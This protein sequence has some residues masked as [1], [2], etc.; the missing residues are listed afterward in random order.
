MSD[1]PQR[2]TVLVVDDTETNIDIMLDALNDEYDVSVALDGLTALENCAHSLP[3]IILLDIMMPDIDGYEVCRR[4]KSDANTRDVPIIFI[5]AMSDPS[6]EVVGLTLGAVDYI[7]KP[8]SIP[9]VQARVKAHLA[10]RQAQLALANQNAI[11]EQK[12]RQRTA[13][14]RQSRLTTITCLGRAAEHRDP[15]TGSHIQRMSNYS[16]ALALACGLSEDEAE[17][18]L[19]AAP[20]HDIGKVGVPDR[21]L[22]KPGPL[23]YDEREIMKTH[24]LIG[25]EILGHEPSKLLQL[26]CQ[27]A[28]THHEKWDGS[29]YPLGLHR[30][31]IPLH[32]RIVA[33]ADVFDAL[34]SERPYKPAWG[35]T[36][37]IEHI[38]AVSGVHFDPALVEHFLRIMPDILAIR[39]RYW[40]PAAS[41]MAEADKAC[42]QVA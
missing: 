27:I 38:K 21:I 29:G 25:G 18:I 22:L 5:T 8:I 1:Q 11:L 42:H 9:I 31:A 15:E 33:I 10:L 14:L 41:P 6:N 32:G 37:A 13:E 30:E 12:V 16:Q 3:D 4:L 39:D 40:T 36:R 23:D 28:L 35:I 2:F 26:A 17:L 24:V 7:T 20:M 19:T 34:T